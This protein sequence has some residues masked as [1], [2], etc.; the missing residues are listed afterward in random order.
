AER[1]IVR[2]AASSVSCGVEL[3]G[4][5]TV[6]AYGAEDQLE[7]G[8]CSVPVDLDRSAL[9]EGHEPA[10]L[11]VASPVVDTGPVVVAAVAGLLVLAGFSVW[12]V[13]RTR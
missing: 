8:L 13:R 2:S 10:L 1:V 6:F 3:K 7:T 12:M 9:G 4:D 11:G 5:V